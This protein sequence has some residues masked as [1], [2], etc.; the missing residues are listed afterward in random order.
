MTTGIEWFDD[1]RPALIRMQRIGGHAWRGLVGGAIAVLLLGAAVLLWNSYS[2]GGLIR[3]MGGVTPQQ[4]ADE[5][6]AHPGPQ[7]PRG[8][9]GPPGPA[10][11]PGQASPAASVPVVKLVAQPTV[12]YEK[13]GPIPHSVA[14]PVCALS[15]VALRP[16][17]KNSD[18]SCQLR[19]GAQLGGEWEIVVS[20]ATCSVTCFS[21]S[22]GK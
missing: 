3:I 18:G 13:S 17:A 2:R 7:G 12:N 21:L 9:Q 6:A 22:T 1:P 5:I 20:G 19:H 11:P 15:K 8:M 10:G 14:Y 4:L 16:D